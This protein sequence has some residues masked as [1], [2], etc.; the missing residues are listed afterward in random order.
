MADNNSTSGWGAEMQAE[1]HISTYNAFLTGTKV[2][3][4][5]LVVILVGM[6]IFL[7]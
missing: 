4:A 5:I 2:G 7:L 6:A 1:E 3:G